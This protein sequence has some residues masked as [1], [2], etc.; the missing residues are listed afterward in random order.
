MIEHK[1]RMIRCIQSVTPTWKY[2]CGDNY[3]LRYLN[4]LLSQYHDDA[5]R[6]MWG[7]RSR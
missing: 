2:F 7:L 1:Y 6:N 3:A 4:M 5:F